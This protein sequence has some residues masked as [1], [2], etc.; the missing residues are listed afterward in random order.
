MCKSAEEEREILSSIY[1]K[2]AYFG[3]LR[4]AAANGASRML[5]GPRGCG[6]S[7][8]IL[9]LFDELKNRNTLPL[10]IDR[11][12]GIPLTNNENYFLYYIIRSI[13]NGVLLHLFEHKE[14][15]KKL[16]SR[17]KEQ[18]SF[19]TECFYDPNTSKDY[20]E[21]AESIRA[22]KRKN[23]FAKAYNSF[24]KDPLNALISGAVSIT[25]SWIRSS[26]GLPESPSISAAKEWFPQITPSKI[27]TIPIG[28]F[29]SLDRN[30][31]I[32]LLHIMLDI[33]ST[34]GYQTTII[35]F[36]KIDEY[37][38]INADI[39]KIVDFLKE[40]LRDTNLLYTPNLSL[41]FS[42]WSE[43]KDELN[44]AGVRFDKFEDIKITWRE[45]DLERLI[46][47]RLLHYS[48]DK[49]QKVTLRSLI[50]DDETRRY[51]IALSGNSP[52]ELIKL[53]GVFYSLEHDMGDIL[54]FKT[55]TIATGLTE[56]CMSHDFLS[57]QKNSDKNNKSNNPKRFVNM[58]LQMRNST[59]TADDLHDKFPQISIK[60]TIN[61]LISFGYIHESPLLSSGEEVIYQVIEPRIKHLMSRGVSMI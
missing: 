31:L 4:D 38:P 18:L 34:V 37:N 32:E 21:A 55:E 8:T 14:D 52:R 10:L 43:A 6:K 15:R 39:Q 26:I 2:P 46:D 45:K 49:N 1:Y 25:S 27:S 22:K 44:L 17:Q 42:I 35:L 11:Y 36:D 19:L 58:L 3:D 23:I 12:D 50:P 28:E 54:S 13:C 16:N 57:Y 56:Y 59:F 7:A 60:S 30:K 5:V 40:T 29:V 61:S 41:V 53:L 47:K 24:V 9:R 48:I 20:I 51:V 33:A